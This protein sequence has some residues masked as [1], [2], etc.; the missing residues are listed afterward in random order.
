MSHHFEVS[1]RWTGNL[2]SGTSD[3]KSYSRDHVIS[4]TGHPDIPGS[5]A[6]QFRGD[7]SRYNPE[8]LLIASLS[9][10]HMLWYLHLCSSHNI[11]VLEYTDQ[12]EGEMQPDS[13]GS[14]KFISATLHPQVTISLT[15]DERKAEE[16]HSEANRLCFIA[17]SVNFPIHHKP[18]IL[19]R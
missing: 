17:N 8:D 18:V 9:A 6:P 7:A 3:Y 14:G 15:S 4:I 16:L 10:C 13:K 2:G 12:A 11:V 5:S 1:L 19:K